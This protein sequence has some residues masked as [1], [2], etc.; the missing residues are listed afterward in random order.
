V[1]DDLKRRLKPGP[2]T[3]IFAAKDQEHNSAVVLREYLEGK[4]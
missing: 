3:L 1:L 4:G 2:V